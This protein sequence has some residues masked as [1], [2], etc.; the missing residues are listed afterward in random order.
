MKIFSPKEEMRKVL[1]GE[2]IGY[3]PRSIPLFTP[4]VDMMKKTDAYFPDAN[5]KAEPMA[6]LALAAH[7]LAN[8]RATMIPWAST[9]E[10]EALG[11]KVINNKEDISTY[12]QFKEK[13]FNSIDEVSFSRDILK[14]AS[15][16]AVFEATKIVRD[17][18]EKK[19]DGAIPI[20]SM[21]QGPFTIAVYSFGVN[22]MFK[23][24][25]KK[26]NDAKKILDIISDLNIVYVNKMID[27]GGD[28][29]VMSDP[30]AEGL[31][32]E[33]FKNLLLPV[34]RK[35]ANE[36]KVE[37]IV[38]IC[39]K[40]AKILEHLPATGFNGLSFDYPKVEFEKIKDTFKQGMK[41]VGS[42]PT[43]THLLDGTPEDVIEEATRW[44]KKGVDV[45]AASC[46]LPQYAP[47]QNVKAMA[48]AIDLWNKEKYKI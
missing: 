40:T 48:D 16:P 12:P 36:V 5:Y 27:S 8:W 31:S 37:K 47:L 19:Y 34:Y 6:R 1:N 21:T 46:G 45:L 38:H 41:I 18:I 20:F 2:P 29:L 28:F 44:F 35:I 25:L 23:L 30:A 26:P 7:E 43:V 3:F 32:G 42:V 13:V 15:L 4:V 33:I 11:C 24:T 14:K 9:V 17:T 39:G 10:M 22:E